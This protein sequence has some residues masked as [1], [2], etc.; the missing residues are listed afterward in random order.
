MDK[1]WQHNYDSGRRAFEE[2]KY[3]QALQY[4]EKAAI[5]KNEYADIFNM[6]GLIYYYNER[7]SD[8][9]LSFERALAIN[10]DYTE[11]SLNLSV[12]YNELG[13][14]DKG[15][16]AYEQAKASR[17][18]SSTYLDPYVKG[19][20]ANMHAAL[21]VIYK[22]MGVYV[23][24]VA[25]FKKALA[26]RPEFVDIKTELGVAYR[27]MKDFDNAV[28]ELL[29]AVKLKKDCAMPRIQLGLTY[30][31]MGRN[32]LAKAEW[33]KVLDFSPDDKMALMYMTLLKSP[34]S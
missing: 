4:L 14:F 27:D 6:L 28:R 15:K 8:A 31:T 18:E 32:E 9:I 29:E 2:R 17:K 16:G 10:P 22:D 13:K 20:V 21:G 11:A 24:A 12:V 1:G 7:Y 5:E 34:L 25:E 23:E 19:R 3:D 33:S 26:L 30:Y